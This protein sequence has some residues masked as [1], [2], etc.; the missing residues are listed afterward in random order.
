MA[1]PVD[2]QGSLIADHVAS[3]THTSDNNSMAD[4]IK[5]A[6][7][8]PQKPANDDKKQRNENGKKD[9]KKDNDKKDKSKK[10]KKPGEGSKNVKKAASPIATQTDVDQSP[11]PPAPLLPM[12]GGEGGLL[13]QFSGI[14]PLVS[15]IPSAI[16]TP[17]VLSN[18]HGN[19]GQL[20][21]SHGSR[22][23]SPGPLSPPGFYQYPSGSRPSSPSSHYAH[24]QAMAGQERLGASCTLLPP[25]SI[26]YDE[27]TTAPN[28]PIEHG[29]VSMSDMRLS[30][31]ATHLD[32][33]H[34]IST[35]MTPSGS[36]LAVN[37]PIQLRESTLTVNYPDNGGKAL[38]H[39]SVPTFHIVKAFNKGW[40]INCLGEAQQV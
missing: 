35:C 25:P 21:S 1:E 22:P 23:S 5:K 8:K 13:P 7:G 18:P 31:S 32:G 20:E 33:H 10:C 38:K 29:M 37:K 16:R 39:H 40:T 12:Y 27:V 19:H 24:Y 36:L 6:N 34:S 14:P 2:E 4:H 3:D 17:V 30:A 15:R 9:A 26:T 28:S 11:S